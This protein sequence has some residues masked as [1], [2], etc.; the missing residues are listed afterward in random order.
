METEILELFE[1]VL[2]EKRSEV[3]RTLVE[4]GQKHKAVELYTKKES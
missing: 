1:K 2:E 3:V 4:A